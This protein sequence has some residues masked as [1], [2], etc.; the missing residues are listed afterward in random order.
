MGGGL[1]GVVPG[2]RREKSFRQ[3]MELESWAGRKP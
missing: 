3:K 2:K 1:V